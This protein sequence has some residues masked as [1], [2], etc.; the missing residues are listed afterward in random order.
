ME[1][2]PPEPALP[3]DAPPAAPGR[4]PTVTVT[5]PA[6]GP[7]AAEAELDRARRVL[8]EDAQRRVVEAQSELSA[9]LQKHRC[10][11][12]PVVAVDGDAVQK[13][14]RVVPLG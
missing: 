12:V 5:G 6:G 13:S 1:L 8:A 10:T 4:P 7:A 11:L 9:V 14:V 2:T 3:A